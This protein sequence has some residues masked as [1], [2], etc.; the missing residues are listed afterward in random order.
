MH[1][2]EIESEFKFNLTKEA[3]RV[4]HRRAPLAIHIRFD[5]IV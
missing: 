2:L 4:K 3:S 5:S 1:D